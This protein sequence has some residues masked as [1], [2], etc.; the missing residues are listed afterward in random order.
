[1]HRSKQRAGMGV[2]AAGLA[3]ACASSLLAGCY[4]AK[5]GS[6]DRLT[7]SPV[8][9]PKSAWPEVPVRDLE[10]MLWAYPDLQPLTPISS[11]PNGRSGRPTELGAGM[12]AGM[13]A[14]V[15]IP[16]ANS[17]TASLRIHRFGGAI[18][19]LN[20]DEE[21]RPANTP[22]D[23]M[24][25]FIGFTP[26]GYVQT[27]LT[28]G[29]T[30]ERLN[31]LLQERERLSAL[32]RSS[33]GERIAQP[34]CAPAVIV[35]ERS[36]YST[37]I[38]FRFPATIPE[39]PRGVILHLWALGANPY[40]KQVIDEF[41]RRGWIIID[42]DPDDGIDR[43][44]DEET[45]EKVLDLEDRK[46]QLSRLIPPISLDRSFAEQWEERKRDPNQQKLD[47][48]NA[49]SLDL[50][51]P[52]VRLRDEADVE[53]AARM[54]AAEIDRTLA[55]NALATEAILD[56]LRTTYSET[57]NLPTVVIG[58]SAGA[59]SAPAVVAR[60]RE[61]GVD[62]VAA[63]VLIGGA[64]NLVEVAARSTFYDGGVMLESRPLN[65]GENVRRI[66]RPNRPSAELVGK[67]GKRYLELCQLDPYHTAAALRGMPVLQV[68][69]IWDT[70]VPADLGDLLY[71]RLGKP[72]QLWHTG[73]HGMLFYFLPGQASWIADWVERKAPP[74]PA[75]DRESKG[76]GSH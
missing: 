46:E 16:T 57:R 17:P 49:E 60:L 34:F 40:E 61:R 4:F 70:W 48:L 10:E 8:L 14:G 73:G 42:I 24:A 75:L 1:M 22:P 30:K 21:G 59:L 47:R 11:G 41:R 56:A 43:D 28:F 54:L 12:G 2:R 18:V 37:G 36:G 52:P 33:P 66:D 5:P 39:R 13:G 23:L 53:P 76:L 50:R 67:L 74:P 29:T 19:K 64:A 44:I 31:A 72:D 69:A 62:T 27:G 7:Q 51:N 65:P 9:L 15:R 68:H 35:E 32:A 55:R 20:V 26:N 3:L 38:G 25:I 63:T 71:E 6:A 58:F 45:V